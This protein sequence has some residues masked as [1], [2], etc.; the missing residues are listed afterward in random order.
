M[1]RLH[2]AYLA[3]FRSHNIGAQGS[4][5]ESVGTPCA[6]S[7]TD[8]PRSEQLTPRH[9]QCRSGWRNFDQNSPGSAV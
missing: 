2:L 7:C 5:R 8:L 6:P 4:L 3:R 9:R 1:S